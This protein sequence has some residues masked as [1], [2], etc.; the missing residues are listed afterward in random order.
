MYKVGHPK[1][2]VKSGSAITVFGEVSLAP[3]A[4]GARVAN[5]KKKHARMI[6]VLLNARL[7]ILPL[8][9]MIY[10]PW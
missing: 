7:S 4:G 10:A 1:I 6:I 2:V 3:V 8:I 9:F 5:K